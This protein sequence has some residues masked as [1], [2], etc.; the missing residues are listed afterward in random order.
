MNSKR[1]V[2]LAM[3][4]AIL[5]SP[6]LSILV[7]GLFTGA[8]VFSLDIASTSWNDEE[9]YWWTVQQMHLFGEPSGYPGYN[10]QLSDMPAWGPYNVFT[11]VPYYIGAFFTGVSSYNFMYV[12]NMAF[13]VVSAALIVLI[14][15]P[16][17][18]QSICC[19]ALLFFQF[20][21]ARYF[22]SGM[23]EGSFVLFATL[24][25]CC[26]VW[27]TMHA[28]DG[29]SR[30]ASSGKA[31]AKAGKPSRWKVLLAFAAIIAAIAL[32]GPMRPFLFAFILVPCFL[33]FR[34]DFGLGKPTR[35]AVFAAAVVVVGVMLVVYVYHAKY[36]VAPYFDAVTIADSLGERITSALPSLLSLHH[37]AISFFVSKFVKLNRQ[38]IVAFTFALTWIALL[39]MWIRAVRAKDRSSVTLLSMLV[40]AEFMMFEA[41]I[42]LYDY[43]Q[44]H[45]MLI[46]LNVVNLIAVV[47]MGGKG[48]LG[49]VVTPRAIVVTIVAV[50]G[51]GGL[52]A[53]PSEYKIPQVGDD[54]LTV[55]EGASLTAELESL[56]PRG[57]DQWENTVAHPAENSGIRLY[58]YLPRYQNLNC[59][60]KEYLAKHLAD[61]TMK[62]KYVSLPAG[63]NT[64]FDMKSKYKVVYEGLDHTIYQ[65]HD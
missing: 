58:F 54:T 31:G 32:W 11:Y 64:D 2:K 50:I 20:L 7:I 35:I 46:A 25:A 24:F 16:D 8:G 53:H 28:D 34:H 40:V 52:V 48:L 30:S 3:W 4:L 44:M 10:E 1:A 17:V 42:M 62:S 49:S 56:M 60:E 39:L 19:I 41:N 55:E 23:V 18:R 33:L 63:Y 21:I 12:L 61:G 14:L 47:W 13:G 5:V 6:L 36:C 22:C 57:E 26:A 15:R 51:V 65:L 37:Q 27:L 43:A 59:C 29:D 38:G 9:H 45:R